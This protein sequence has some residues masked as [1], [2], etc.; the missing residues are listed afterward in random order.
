LKVAACCW[1]SIVVGTS[2]STWRPPETALKRARTATSVLPKPTSP[3]TSRSI[4]RS[5]SMSSV[6]ASIARSWSSVSSYGKASS[7]A[8]IHSSSGGNGGRTWFWRRA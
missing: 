6:T 1:A 5:H 7:S 4:G 8:A 3:H 2:T